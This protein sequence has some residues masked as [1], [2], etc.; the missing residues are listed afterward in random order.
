VALLLVSFVFAYAIM[1]GTV[2]N[3]I[4]RLLNVHF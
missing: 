3:Y 4:L 2:L 1:A